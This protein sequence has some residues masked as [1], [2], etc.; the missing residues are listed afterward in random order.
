METV[1][2]GQDTTLSYGSGGDS[3][4]SLLPT[5]IGSVTLD[6]PTGDKQAEVGISAFFAGIGHHAWAEEWTDFQVEGSSEREATI[7]FNG[8]F[9]ASLGAVLGASARARGSVFIRDITSGSDELDNDEI[10]DKTVA[11]YQV[12]PARP[13]GPIDED[14]RLLVTLQPGHTYR[15]GVRAWVWAVADGTSVASANMDPV[16]DPGYLRYSDINIRWI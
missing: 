15:V 16:G 10:F 9:A 11:V 2:T 5:Q 7:S 14:D 6:Y 1:T 4:S 13:S 3:A 8:E 12:L